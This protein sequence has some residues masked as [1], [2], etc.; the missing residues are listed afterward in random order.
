MGRT[1]SQKSAGTNFCGLSRVVHLFRIQIFVLV[2]EY[3]N[4]VDFYAASA[5][6]RLKTNLL[7]SLD[8]IIFII[9]S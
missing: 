8:F 9:I 2:V 7:A 3:S 6:F 1:G 4:A 5:F